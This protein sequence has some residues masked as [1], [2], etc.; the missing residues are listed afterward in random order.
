MEKIV[1][2]GAVIKFR[3]E[4]LHKN[5]IFIGECPNPDSTGFNA[6]RYLVNSLKANE[7]AEFYFHGFSSFVSIMPDGT[8]LMPHLKLYYVNC[9]GQSIYLLLGNSV[10]E[11]KDYYGFAKV[12]SDFIDLI[13]P[14]LTILVNGLK[15]RNE[16]LEVYGASED[17]KLVTKLKKFGVK[18]YKGRFYGIEGYLSAFLRKRGFNN[19]V[20]ISKYPSRNSLTASEKILDVLSQLLNIEVDLQ[21]IKELSKRAEDIDKMFSKILKK[22]VKE[23]P[24]RSLEII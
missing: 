7:A 21:E 3:K 5:S 11:Q 20:L 8:I 23:K 19:I 4:K 18:P 13:R 2:D 15:S 24:S 14:N 6:V 10:V 12:F 16:R 1:F 9:E 17:W 22:K